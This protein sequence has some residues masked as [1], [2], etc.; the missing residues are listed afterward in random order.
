[1]GARFR[2]R[3]IPRPVD[4]CGFTLVEIL[5]GV[6]MLAL[7]ASGSAMLI[8]VANR[9]LGTS[10]S[11]NNAQAAIDS[12]ISR[13][14]KLAEDYTCCPG[15]CTSNAATITTAR[16]SGRCLG[17]ANDST[18]YF[19]QL[20]ADIPAFTTACEA[21]TLTANLILAIQSIA[22][23]PDVTRTVMV[24][25]NSDLS[26]HRIR[27]IYSGTAANTGIARVVKL[28]PTVAAWC[29]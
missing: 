12:D 29:P 1:M 2:Q 19:P 23:L 18:Y 4:Q 24:D 14:R 10:T 3:P 7:V 15:S 25:D 5:I 13:V 21:G 26:S 27:L 20:A 11:Q 8:T 16:G 17:N 22:S 28:V 6:V 9:M